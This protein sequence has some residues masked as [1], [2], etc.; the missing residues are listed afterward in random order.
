MIMKTVREYRE[1]SLCEHRI[2]LEFLE[3]WSRESNV[4][5]QRGGLCGVSAV[6]L[7]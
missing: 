6:S 5:L 3:L 2:T 4:Y 7:T 1:H